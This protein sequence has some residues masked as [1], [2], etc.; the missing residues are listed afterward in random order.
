MII[1]KTITVARPPD[2]AFKIFA[3]EMTQW[4]PLDKYSFLGPDATL[5]MEP[6][7]GGR[8]V[9][10]APDGREHVIGEVVR[11]EPGVRLTYTWTHME[12][13]GVT[14]IDIR[15]TADGNGTRIDLAHG[16]FD[17]LADAEQLSASYDSGW[18]EVLAA[19]AGY[20]SK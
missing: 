3:E 10:T 17:K 11:Y 12:G 19:F 13:K 2:V 16:G 4:W 9:E 8:F 14:E 20:A 7:A 5:T 18:N 1:H 6:R 15:F